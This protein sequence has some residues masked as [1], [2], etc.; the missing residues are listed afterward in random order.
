MLWISQAFLSSGVRLQA[1][2]TLLSHLETSLPLQHNLCAALC[3]GNFLN[4]GSKKGGVE[5]IYVQASRQ[6]LAGRDTLRDTL[7][8]T[9]TLTLTLTLIGRDTLCDTLAV[10]GAA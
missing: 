3:C 2:E 5:G 8:V 10:A 4:A 7:A 9:L 6:L 1:L